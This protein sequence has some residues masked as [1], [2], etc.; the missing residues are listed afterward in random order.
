[1]AYY[2]AFWALAAFAYL[3]GFLPHF[4]PVAREAISRVERGEVP[5]I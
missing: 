4:L 2:V 3:G 1:V 5:P